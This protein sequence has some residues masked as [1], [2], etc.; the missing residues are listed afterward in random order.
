MGGQAV[1]FT[2]NPPEL[3]RIAVSSTA[4]LADCVFHPICASDSVE[5]M[6]E[7]A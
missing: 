5:K 2:I 7:E 1:I 6:G 3:Q 4:N